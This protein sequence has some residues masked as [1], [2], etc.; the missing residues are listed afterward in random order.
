MSGLRQREV[1]RRVFIAELTDAFHTYR[2]EDDDQAPIYSLLPTGERANRVFIAGTLLTTSEYESDGDA[3]I[4]G[5]EF[6]DPTDEMTAYAP[7]ESDASARL[8]A[9]SPPEYVALTAKPRTHETAAGTQSVG[10]R[11][12][13][14]S[15]ISRPTRD[16][17]I[18]DTAQQTLDRI[19]DFDVS[20]PPAQRTTDEYDHQPTDYT[21]AV[22]TALASIE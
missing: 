4:W 20:Y 7:P 18:A 15:V 3:P 6:K 9:L 10:L 14:I 8:P 22:Q 13:H 5:M 2:T 19:S 16:H 21:G 11:A 17:W 12:E 1:A